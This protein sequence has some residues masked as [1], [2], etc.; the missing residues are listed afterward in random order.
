MRYKHTGINTVRRRPKLTGETVGAGKGQRHFAN[1]KEAWPD[2]ALYCRSLHSLGG[3]GS[4]R[5]KKFTA[6]FLKVK[7]REQRRKM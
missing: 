5:T 4:R 7:G 6:H 3:L 1:A 2:S